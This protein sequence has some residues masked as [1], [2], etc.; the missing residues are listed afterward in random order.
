MLYYKWGKYNSK[1]MKQNNL[2]ILTNEIIR[3]NIFLKARLM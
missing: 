2:R 3:K 1:K